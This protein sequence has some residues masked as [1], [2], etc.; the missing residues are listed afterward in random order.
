VSRPPVFTNRCC[1]LVSDHSP[2]GAG[3]A[4]RDH[5]VLRVVGDQA[6]LQPHLVGA[7]VMAAKSR[8]RERLLA[9]FNPLFRRPALVVKLHHRRRSN[10]ERRFA[11]RFDL[12]TT[13][14][15]EA[16][17]SDGCSRNSS[18]DEARL[19]SPLWVR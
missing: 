17:G 4:S 19:I 3:S 12:G 6:Q 10:G 8:Y 1:K 11:T 14:K 7:E 13:T 9:L 15:R 18:W 16:K 2:I 5:K